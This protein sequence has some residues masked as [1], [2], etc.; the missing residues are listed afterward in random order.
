MRMYVHRSSSYM[1]DLWCEWVS[2]EQCQSP[3]GEAVPVTQCYCREVAHHHRGMYVQY[4]YVWII[5]CYI[6]FIILWDF[7]IYPYKDF[8]FLLVQVK[9][10]SLGDYLLSMRRRGYA[11]V[12]AEQTA[13]SKDIVNFNFKPNT[14]LVL[15]YVSLPRPQ[16]QLEAE[17]VSMCKWCWGYGTLRKNQECMSRPKPYYVIMIFGWIM[18]ARL[19]QYDPLKSNICCKMCAV[20]GSGTLFGS[21]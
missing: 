20:I 7:F 6:C 4:V 11:L 9:L 21:C 17:E 13:N 10:P 18:H 1:R 14:V 16:Q 8:Q 12:G 2:A 19:D 15:G 5:G 3:R